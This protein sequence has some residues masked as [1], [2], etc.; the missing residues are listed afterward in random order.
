[1]KGKPLIMYKLTEE[2]QM[3]LDMVKKLS[4]TRIAPRAEEIDEK[5]EFPMDIVNIYRQNGLLGLPFM[6]FE[7]RKENMII[8]CLVLEEIAKVCSN[9]SHVLAAHWLGM[10]PIKIAANEKQAEK[11]FPMLESKLA[12]FSLTEPEAGSDAGNVRT[13]AV[14]DG[15]DYLLNGAKCFCTDGSVSD[16]VTIFTRT[17]PDPK[18]GVKGLSAF[19]VEKAMPGYK[20]G[21]LERQMGMRG[22]P[23]CEI[24]LEDCRVPKE[25]LLGKEG[26]GFKIAMQTLDRTRPGDA[27][28]AI[29]IAEGAIEESMK[30][31]KDRVQFGRPITDFQ[32]IQ[33]MFADMATMTEAARLLVYKAAM[34]IDEGRLSPMYSAMAKYFATDTAVAVINQAMQAMGGYG[35]MKEFSIERKYRDAKLLQIVEGT[36]QIQRLVVARHLL[37]N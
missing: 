13:K 10:T 37:A 7:G 3:L 24:I 11:Y 6:E 2:E 34:L 36:N 33:F 20:I 30:Y 26:D 8:K 31:G 29:G 12:A 17:N 18:S 25:N 21:K 4:K 15:D 1:M 14:L 16:V 27:A 35:Y 28:L 23:A 5:A 32:A 22:T 9:S 19:I